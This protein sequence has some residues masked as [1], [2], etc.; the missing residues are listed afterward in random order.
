MAGWISVH[1]DLMQKGYYR[2]SEYVHLWIH[3]LLT[4]NHEDKEFLF[5]GKIMRV[6][7]GQLVTGRKELSRVTSIDENKVYRILKT[8]KS[9][10]QIEQQKTNKFTVI[11]VVNYDKYQ[12]AE[13]QNEQQV[14][15]KRTAS[16]QQVNTNNNIITKIIKQKHI[17]ENSAELSPSAAC[18]Y[19]KIISLYR[20]ML[21]ECP[22]LRVLTPA[23]KKHIKARWNNDLRTLGEWKNYFDFVSQSDFLMGRVDGKNG[24]PPF[25]VDLEWLCKQANY[26]KVAERKYHR[27]ERYG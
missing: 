24:A 25:I 16:E 20:E 11:T 4:A 9:E 22:M 17:G 18:P 10:Q 5:N 8:L 15:S 12:G 1:R 21:P 23:R 19:D 26:A 13:Q 3:L 7:R 2:D 14:N 27:S 6:K